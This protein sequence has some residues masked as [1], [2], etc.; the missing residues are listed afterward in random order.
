MR[1]TLSSEHV[2]STTF[3]DE[4]GQVVY[5]SDTPFGLGSRSTKLHKTTSHG[6]RHQSTTV[7]SIEW[8]TYSSTI[9]RFDGSKVKTK[10]FIP[11]SGFL[12]KKRTFVGPDGHSYRW[13]LESRVVVLYLNA[14]PKVEMARFHRR[15]LGIIGHKREPYLEVSSQVEHILDLVILTFIYVEKIR[16][17][18]EKASHTAT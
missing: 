7:G 13:E 18:K 9:L 17:D 5:K 12:K 6:L 16:M 4:H 2:R 1:F 8:H 15:S 14:T 3:T 11:S 10:D